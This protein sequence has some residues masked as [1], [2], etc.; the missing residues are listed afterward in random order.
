MG[1]L[2]GKVALVTGAAQG[3]GAAY[4]AALAAEGARVAVADVADPQPTASAIDKAG[5]EAIALVC[6][7]TDP[8]S[9]ASA[10]TETIRRLGSLDILV[11]NAA[12]FGKLGQRPF[13]EI[14]SEEWDKVSAVN[15][16]GIFECCKAA[17]PVMRRQKGGKIV[18]I[19]SATVFKGAPMMLHYV[20][21]KGA[22]IALTRALARE[23]GG[24]DIC[25]NCIAP[26]LIMSDNVR[27][28]ADYDDA[29]ISANTATRALR[30][31]AAPGDLIG[32][33]IFLC[34]AESDFMTGQTV[35]VDGGS[36][37]H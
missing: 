36:V 35:V 12:I 10:V 19:A 14:T 11:N 3:I 23:V 27:V 17:V 5:G 25:V 22:V 16:R 26:G 20:A 32:P 7:V 37:M 9:V 34:S 33:L 6:D 4:A 15:I 2:T 31:K 18:N 24:D 13:T 21:S 30:R 8:A 29:F 1:R 28:N